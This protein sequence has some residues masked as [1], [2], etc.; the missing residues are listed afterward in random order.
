MKWSS[1]YISI[2]KMHIEAWIATKGRKDDR[3]DV[4]NTVAKEIKRYHARELSE[5]RLPSNLEMVRSLRLSHKF[6]SLIYVNNRKLKPGTKTI[7]RQ[8]LQ[9]QTQRAVVGF[10]PTLREH[11]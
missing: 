9:R 2:L 4:I 11:Q 5:E 8:P 3:T 7:Q 1:Q 6:T 10:A